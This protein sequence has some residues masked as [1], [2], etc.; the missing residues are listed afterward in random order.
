[1]YTCN[2]ASADLSEEPS[3]VLHGRSSIRQLLYCCYFTVTSSMSR[4]KSPAR[5]MCALVSFH[6]LE[7]K[8]NLCLSEYNQVRRNAE[9]ERVHRHWNQPELMYSR[10][11]SK[12]GHVQAYVACGESARRGVSPTPTN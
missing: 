1:M 5:E 10:N 7:V 8:H 2:I 6:N 9:K 3:L 12:I 11:A 4:R